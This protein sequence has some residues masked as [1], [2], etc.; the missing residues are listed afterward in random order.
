MSQEQISAK[1][2]WLF[3]IIYSIIVVLICCI[4]Y[5]NFFSQDDAAFEMLGFFRQIGRIWIQGELPLIVDSMYLGGNEVIDLTRGIFLPQNILI[6]IITTQFNFI[7]LAGNILAFINLL[8]VSLSALSIAKSLK[9]GKPYSY[10]FASIVVIQPVF[11]YFYLGEWWNA[12][13]GQAWAMVSIATFLLLVKDY[14]R[15]NILLNFISV[16][17]LLSAGWPHGLIGYVFFVLVTLVYEFNKIKNLKTFLGVCAPTVLAFI[18]T[19]LI[20]SE[21]I[22]SNDLINRIHGYYSRY[23]NYTLP[24]STILLGFNPTSYESMNCSGLKLV[25][26]SLGFSTCF[27]PVIFFYRDIKSLL[28]K[29]A[30]LKWILTLIL[31]FFILTQMPSQF[32]PL[33]WPFRF[34]PFLSLFICM[35]VFYVLKNAP[36]INP[37][38]IVVNKKVSIVIHTFV[39]LFLLF[40][41]DYI[42]LDLLWPIAAF[43]ILFYIIDKNIFNLTKSVLAKFNKKFCILIVCCGF[44]SFFN[45]I[46]VHPYFYILQIVSL[47]LVLLT[48]YIVEQKNSIL[49]ISVNIF[50]LVIMLMGMPLLGGTFGYDTNLSYQSNHI[51]RSQKV[52]LQGF[53]LSLTKNFLVPEVK[54]LSELSSSQFGLYDIKSINGYT[55]VGNKKME[56]VLPVYQKVH[57]SFGVS[58]TLNNILKKADNLDDCQAI[59]MRISTIIVKLSDYGEFKE[60]FKQC[61]YTLV[62]VADKRKNLYVSL[63]LTKTKGWENNIPYAFPAIDGLE[64]VE[65]KNNSDLVNIPAHNEK[66][67]LIFPRLWWKGYSAEINGLP[68]SVTPDG[69]GMLVSVE[70]PPSAHGVLRLSYFP[71]T[72]RYLWFLPLLALAGLMVL[73]FCCKGNKN[74]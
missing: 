27:L 19:T 43:L 57:G 50:I 7:Q 36:T 62:D 58:T 18:F 54:R 70:V 41:I 29:D 69:S 73:L 55:P 26:L 66:I 25:K 16:I 30:R 49:F 42:G 21:I 35:F 72:W 61:G 59:I 45:I 15:K 9:L 22:Y 5:K 48:P 63:P 38:G 67:T 40:I 47:W 2:A 12:G 10:A 46:G 39:V 56:V 13:N 71:V 44:L 3:S 34:I 11:L 14:S 53:V 64:V 1:Q 17:F 60:Q 51:Q 32:G 23:R 31:V 28:Q 68:L 33:R 74:K 65:H 24:W 20:Y 6:S 8:L 4:F 37:R 52:N